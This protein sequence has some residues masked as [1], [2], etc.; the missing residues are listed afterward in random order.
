MLAAAGQAACITEI[1]GKAATGLRDFHKMITELRASLEFPPHELIRLVLE[2]SGYAAMLRESG[3]DEDT[4][5]L[6]NVEELV[7]AAKQFHDEDPTRTLADFLEQITL[8]SDVDGWDEQ[9]DHV[10]VMTLH[11]SKGFN[12]QWYI[13]LP[14]KKVFL[15]HERSMANLEG[16]GGGTPAVLVGKDE[17]HEGTL[18]L[19]CPHGDYCGQTRYA[20]PAA[21]STNCR[22][23]WRRSICR[24]PA[25]RRAE[26]PSDWRAKTAL[27]TKD[28]SVLGAVPYQPP[29]KRRN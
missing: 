23:M 12:F 28:R 15:P 18:S 29:G 26:Q 20:I 6:A 13:S 5:R 11:S 22:G 9:A 1:K 17:G 27:A 19:P 7:T 14:W 21:F 24:W 25:T 8:A 3:E 2:K 4:D 16:V 10:S